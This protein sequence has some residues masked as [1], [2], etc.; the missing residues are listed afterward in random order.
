MLYLLYP[1][2]LYNDGTEQ[3]R[4]QLLAGSESLQ[5]PGSEPCVEMLL[6]LWKRVVTRVYHLY[7]LS[8]SAYFIFLQLNDDL[9]STIISAL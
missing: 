2:S 7:Q 5:L 9:V 3:T 4:K 1:Q 6:D 8:A